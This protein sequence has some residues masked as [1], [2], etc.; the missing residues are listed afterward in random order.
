M[1]PAIC[2]FLALFL[3]GLA[4]ARDIF[5][6]PKP[7]DVPKLIELLKDE[8][9]RVH[10]AL[11]LNKLGPTAK[12]AI[13][14]LIDILGDNDLVVRINVFGAIR[15]IGR[16][17]VPALTKALKSQDQS[18][19]RSAALLLAEIKPSPKEVIPILIE[20][21]KSKTREF[22]FTGL[23]P[24]TALVEIGMPVIPALSDA[25]KDKDSIVRLNVVFILSGIG[26]HA[27]PVLINA[28]DD[29][30]TFVRY[31]AFFGLGEIGPPAKA[32]VPALRKVLAD[33][34]NATE[35]L[36]K[37]PR[38][39]PGIIEEYKTYKSVHE[40]AAD[41]LKKIDPEAAAKAGVK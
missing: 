4:D 26:K 32:A 38:L 22:R 39:L 10:A 17:A 15:N 31:R 11:G 37:L 25:M 6:D 3:P 18:V 28:L 41:A 13:P 19:R 5:T 23:S 30:N 21:L 14:G 8:N 34:E 20:T 24:A 35:S 29:K 27:T 1:K 7:E 12:A 33:K 36:P 9:R 40:A 2:C 16:P